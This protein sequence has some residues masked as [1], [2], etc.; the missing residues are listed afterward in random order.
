[1]HEQPPDAMLREHAR[2]QDH[3]V[4]RAALVV[5]YQQWREAMA[6]DDMAL[7]QELHQRRTFLEAR[8]LQLTW[9]R[10]Q[11]PRARKHDN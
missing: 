2:A 9:E 11:T 10:R 3:A 4:V 8:R 5:T 7:A 6:A 1:M